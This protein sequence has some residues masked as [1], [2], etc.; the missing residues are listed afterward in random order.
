MIK[1]ISKLASLIFITSALFFTAC[2]NNEDY[3]WN[4]VDPGIQYISGPDTI[5]GNNISKFNFYARPRGGSKFTWTVV[6]GPVS[7]TPNATNGFVGEVTANSQTDTVGE[8]MVTET[9]YGGK[10][11]TSNISFKI[12]SSCPSVCLGRLGT[13]SRQ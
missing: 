1:Y 3:D 10:T 13:S 12:Q 11:A 7:V 2:N 8:I 5:K 6:R 4:K 9:T